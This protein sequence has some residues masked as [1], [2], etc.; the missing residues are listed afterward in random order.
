MP[1]DVYDFRSD[2]RN[3]VITPEIRS[4]FLRME[5]GCTAPRHSHDLGHEV[6]LVLDGRAEFEIDGARAVLGPGQM[7]FAYAGQMHQ[8][9]VI[10]DQPMTMYL[11]VTPHVEPTHTFWDDHGRK[12]PPRYGVPTAAERAAEPPSPEPI[13]A[14]AD[15]HVAAARALA[16]TAASNAAAQ[17]AGAAAVKRALAAGDPAAAKAAVDTMWRQ[18]SETYTRLQALELVWNELAVRVSEAAQT[19]SEG[20]AGLGSEPEG[21]KMGGDQPGLQRPRDRREVNIARRRVGD[22]RRNGRGRRHRRHG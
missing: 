9:K 2:V 5:P 17:D 11:S 20:R 21:T 6:F 15:R 22:R 3:V 19:R 16:Q 14:L 10:G 4:R 8:V 18:I 1:F 13:P 12:L 7:C